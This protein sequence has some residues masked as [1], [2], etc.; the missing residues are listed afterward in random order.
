MVMPDPGIYYDSSRKQIV[1]K[2]SNRVLAKRVRKADGFEW[3]DP[4]GGT[5][6]RS[7]LQ[8]FD[9]VFVEA[10]ELDL[11]EW[12]RT[13]LLEWLQWNDPNGAYTDELAD[14]GDY[15][16]LTREEASELVMEKVRENYESPAEMR[17]LA[18]AGR[19]SERARR[20]R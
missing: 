13:D 18:C 16:R 14:A 17:V 19:A 3:A 2:R 6:S 11:D 1:E 7:D 20:R 9:E 4:F 5:F 15:D 8:D 10:V 12:T